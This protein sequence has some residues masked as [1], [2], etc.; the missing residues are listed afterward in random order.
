MLITASRLDA[1]T[2]RITAQQRAAFD[3]MQT[4][5]RTFYELNGGADWSE[6]LAFAEQTYY[7][8][9]DKFGDAA[10]SAACD[11]YDATMAELGISVPPSAPSTPVTATRASTA[12]ATSAKASSGDFS[13][14]SYALSEMAYTDV[15]RAANTT[16]IDN[17][18]R[19]RE[20]G[21]RYA[22]VPTGKET[23]GFCLMLASLGFNY[24]SRKTAGDMGFGFNRFHDRCDC[25]VVAGDDFTEVE[26]YDPDWLYSVYLDARK[27]VD[28]GRIRAGMAGAKASEID[29]RITDSICNEIGKRVLG[30]SWEGIPTDYPKGEYER[31]TSAL[32]S[33]GLATSITDRKD[34]P[35]RMGGLSWGMADAT[36]GGLPDAVARLRRERAEGGTA[37]AGH[38]V[39]L[40]DGIDDAAKSALAS[41]EEGETALLID[42][43]DTDEATGMTPM[44]RITR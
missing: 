12:V 6:M 29:K 44:R 7:S 3:F 41:L 16:T 38:Y 1:Y 42:P 26:G 33:H 17:A 8:C 32:A 24:R 31:F 18:K 11:A 14:F 19:D 34:A 43:N 39:L 2:A 30:W 37:T 25:R 35:L 40:V 36:E 4:S 28:P 21:V 5:L 9:V 20:K 23:C 27:T 15:G 13:A 10:S 22:R